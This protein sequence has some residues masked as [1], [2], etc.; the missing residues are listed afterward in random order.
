MKNNK[1]AQFLDMVDKLDISEDR[2]LLQVLTGI[3][4][5]ILFKYLSE[6]SVSKVDNIPQSAMS[7]LKLLVLVRT[8]N[9][10]LFY[11]WAVLQQCSEETFGKALPD[12]EVYQ[13]IDGLGLLK[14]DREKLSLPANGDK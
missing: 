9:P 8:R 11:E 1:K 14:W 4:R 13:K 5:S 3:G 2:A 10:E 6:D 7:L 12:A